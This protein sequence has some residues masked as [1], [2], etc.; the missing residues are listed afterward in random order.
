MT[1]L[2]A[3][4]LLGLAG[5]GANAGESAPAPAP[6]PPPQDEGIVRNVERKVENSG[7]A[8]TRLLHPIAKALG[9]AADPG[10]TA[11]FVVNARPAGEE[12][13]IPVGRVEAEHSIKVKSAAELKAM[14]ADFDSVKTQHDA[15]RS[16]FPPAAK[17]VAEAAKAAK[18]KKPK[19]PASAQSAPAAPQ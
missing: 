6:Q 19:A 13:Y 14:E 9:V 8:K 5:G 12:D 10:K 17:A 4:A 18:A 15:L 1:M 3:I 2:A 16:A 7:L 11:D